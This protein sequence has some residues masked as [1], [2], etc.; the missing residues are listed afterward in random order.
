MADWSS[1]FEA[2]GDE[3]GD[4]DRCEPDESRTAILQYLQDYNPVVAYFF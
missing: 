2:S 3:D 1:V 4:W